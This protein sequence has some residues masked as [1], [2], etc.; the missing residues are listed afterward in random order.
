[1]AALTAT[2]LHVLYRVADVAGDPV[3]F[4]GVVA[5]ALLAGVLLGRT[6]PEALSVPLTL[7]LALVGALLYVPTIPE[8]YD[9]VN[10]IDLLLVD[11]VALLTGLSVLRIINAGVW[12]TAFAPVPV[13]LSW[14]LTARRQYAYGA[15]VGAAAL[16]FFVL[17]GDVSPAT[18]LFGVVAAAGAVGVG[19]VDRRGGRLTDADGVAVVVAAIVV[20]TVSVTVVPV[21]TGEP[22]L[23]S[24]G[25]GA[26]T[27]EGSLTDAGGEVAVQGS[28][29][30]SPEVRFRVESDE[31]RYWKVGAYDRYSGGGWTR[32]ATVTEFDGQSGPP[33]PTRPVRQTFTAE[34]SATVLPAAWKPVSVEGRATDVTGFGG[35]QPADSLAPGDEYSVLSRVSNARPSQLREA[36]TDY[37]AI[38]REQYTRLPSSTPDRLGEF[39]TTLTANAENPYDTA[40]VIETHLEAEKNYSLDVQRPSG[41]VADGFLFEMDAGY[42]TYFATTM[43]AMLRSQGIPARFAVGYTTGQ[44]IDADEWVVRGLNAHA[45]VEVYFPGYGWQQF[46]PT[47]AGPRQAARQARID[48]AREENRSGVDVQGSTPTA[49]P[50]PT[51]TAASEAPTRTATPTGGADGGTTPPGGEET[52]PGGVAGGAVDGGS[53]ETDDGGFSL[54]TPTRDQLAFGFLVA[55]GAVAAVRRTGAPERISRA[56][57]LRRQPRS[58]DPEADVRRAYERLE[59]LLGRT[60]RERRAGETPRRY[61]RS[62][63]DSDAER[64]G[65]LYERAVYAGRATDED[66]AEAIALVDALI[67]DRTR[68]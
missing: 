3:L 30:L 7:A 49:T 16:V 64:V 58:G 67:D 31:G 17:T 21:G 59:T 62:L 29:S 24:G 53:D 6:L 19:D 38:D 35:V 48:D 66:A 15:A 37:S 36:G 41:D 61:L 27:V 42:C 44:Q 39:T 55:L 13:F 5:G 63:G 22:L 25:G 2:Y 10:R 23:P 20:L 68:L 40:R 4:A 8:G 9:L 45:W 11:V 1:M 65:E 46:D 47:P 51:A 57:W 50:T 14:Y 33:G 43:V 52:P 28:I 56:L 34:T 60:R 26:D 18:T 12:A 54:P 32:T